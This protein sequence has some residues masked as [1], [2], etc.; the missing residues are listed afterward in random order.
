M[1]CKSAD[2]YVKPNYAVQSQSM[3]KR[4]YIKYIISCGSGASAMLLYASILQVCVDGAD[5]FQCTCAVAL[6]MALLF[7]IAYMYA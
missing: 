6:Y 4:S 3:Y 1:Q 5:R 7:V 2:S